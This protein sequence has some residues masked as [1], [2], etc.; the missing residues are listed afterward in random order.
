M[1]ETARPEKLRR[2]TKKTH[3][4]SD[5]TGKNKHLDEQRLRQRD[6]T[7]CVKRLSPA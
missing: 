2:K 5:K 7:L 3:P 1:T 6:L 4:Y